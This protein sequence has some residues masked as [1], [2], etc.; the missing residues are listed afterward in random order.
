MTCANSNDGIVKVFVDMRPHS[1]RAVSDNRI[2]VGLNIRGYCHHR[3]L[4]EITMMT[5]KEASASNEN[6]N[7]LM[8]H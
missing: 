2:V 5:M 8:T 4:L 6:Y 3:Y 7:D 1:L